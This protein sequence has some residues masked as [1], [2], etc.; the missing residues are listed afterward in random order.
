MEIDLFIRRGLI[1][2]A[3]R[4][5]VINKHIFSFENG[6]RVDNHLIET[7]TEQI[8][9][10]RYGVD[11]IR[12]YLVF[13]R[14]YNVWVETNSGKQIR[15][16]FSTYFR[17]NLKQLHQNYIDIIR[18]IWD[19]CIQKQFENHI[20]AILKNETIEIQNL[21]IN[22]SGVI[23]TRSKTNR[24]KDLIITIQ[25]LRL[26]EYATY[27]ALYSTQNSDKEHFYYSYKNDWN[28]QLIYQILKYLRENNNK[29]NKD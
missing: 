7:P 22:N 18:S 1:D 10:F 23:V 8:I 2:N 14:R 19:N 24:K 3:K 27:F 17:R 11:W 12:L 28:S 29:I 13:G 26:K 21:L 16:N 9:K 4:H 5:L 25:D 15:I 6:D 20:T